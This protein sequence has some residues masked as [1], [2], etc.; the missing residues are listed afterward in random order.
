[1][2]YGRSIKVAFD[3]LSGEILEADDVFEVTKDAFAIRKQFHM[4]EVELYCCECDQK[5]YVSTSKYDRLHFK[6]GPNADYCFLK[7]ENLSPEDKEKFSQVYHAKESARHHE[8]KNKI[9][10]ALLEVPGIDQDSV[11]VD[12]RFIVKGNEKRRP[13]VYCKFGDKELVFEIQLSDLSLRYILNRYFFYKKH[14]I[15]LIWILDNFDIHNQGQLERDI[16]Y[17]TKFENFFKLDETSES[18]KLQCEYKFPFLTGDN[19]LLTKWLQKT[20]SLNQIKFDSENYQIYYY[21][22]EQGKTAAEDEQRH[23]VALIEEQIK[24]KAEEERYQNALEIVEGII[25]TIKDLKTRGVLYY[26]TVTKAINELTPFEANVLNEK[27]GLIGKKKP[28][29][30]EWVL[31]A[32]NSD[33]SFLDF[34]LHCEK[35]ELDVNESKADG[36]TAFQAICKNNDIHKYVVTKAILERGYKFTES[37]Q[38]F[39]NEIQN[40]E[41]DGIYKAALF[42]V[43]KRVSNRKLINDVYN[44]GKLVLI[45]ESARLKAITGYKYKSDQWIAF[46]NNAIEYHSEYWE[47]IEN[48]FKHYG[49]WEM[50]IEKDRKLSFQNKVTAFYKN[51]PQQK[52][53]F[54]TVYCELFPEVA[55]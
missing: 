21:N 1:M 3:K 31:T 36:M 38:A 5:L 51:M 33:N 18:F 17:L 6:H 8:L 37:D 23:K 47:Y 54:E 46:A 30:I 29:V 15:Y 42:T 24:K 4:D 55:F 25:T 49:L 32:S 20:V 10:K 19:R 16:K 7:D 44:H 28:A 50:L 9:G 48:V 41:E 26:V 43:I 39:I 27:L 22:L 11:A 14:G 45:L 52:Y 13:D 12:N 34:I 35:I 53:D 2:S 40:T